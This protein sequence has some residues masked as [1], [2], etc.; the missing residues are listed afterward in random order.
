MRHLSK[1]RDRYYY[2]RKLPKTTKNLVISLQTDNKSEANFITAIINAR[3]N[4]IFK[5]ITLNFEEELELIQTTVKE[6]VQEA[7][8]EYGYYSQKREQNYKYT[9]KKGS[10]RLGSHPKAISKA[11]V[12]L[13]DILH[14]PDK[15]EAY[16]QIVTSSNM[17]D[18]FS[19][20]Y[21]SLSDKNQDRMIDE[22][23][24][25]EIEL[26]YYDKERNEQRVK[27]PLNTP[28]YLDTSLSNKIN[29]YNSPYSPPLQQDPKQIKYYSKTARELLT[30]Y[31]DKLKIKEPQRVQRSIDMLLDIVDK[32]YLIDYTHED[33]D[34]FFEYVL[35][36]PDRNSN[37]KLFN[38]NSFKKVIEIAREKKIKALEES[39]LYS[40]VIQINK[41]LDEVVDREYLDKNRLKN[42]GNLSAKT[43]D[44]KRKEY[45]DTQLNTL[46]NESK[47]YTIEFQENLEKTPSR[48]WIPLI[49]LYQGCRVNEIAQLYLN[50]VIERD[51]YHFFKIKIEHDD[52]QLKNPT[53][54]RTIPIHPKLIDLGILKF[55]DKQRKEGHTRVF[56]ELYHTKEKGY[57]Q[58]Y[59]KVYN[60][61][62]K[63]WLDEETLK[64]LANKEILL[65]LHSFRH[66]F[67]GSLK[68]L[69][70]D[71][72]LDY[73]SGHKNSSQSQSRY[74]KFRSK[75][76]YDMIS[77]CKYENLDLEQLQTKLL[78]FY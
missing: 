57:G 71:G 62:K 27:S 23:I 73:L 49:L 19:N 5:D 74:G 44:K 53:S 16:K 46:F 76:K 45:Y 51:G 36:L 63:E 75:V 78:E 12:A 40:K 34:K 4:P 41:F 77:K 9:T 58:A 26:L 47:Q 33:M 72:I 70:E 67:S 7:K 37:R 6:Y 48:I 20:T 18:I 52:Q 66:N 65:D 2:K 39:T 64:R 22:V 30:E 3:I 11:I 29:M 60:E 10:V 43:D 1:H 59:S 54:K 69:I 14:S 35:D 24:K 8:E 68:G 13:T 17:I 55:I 25:G 28:T 38:E 31:I 56:P 42:K 50:Q 15:V 32:E 61:D 21:H